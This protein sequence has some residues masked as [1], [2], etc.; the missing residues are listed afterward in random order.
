MEWRMVFRFCVMLMVPIVLVTPSCFK[1][2]F[3]TDNG[4]T[5]RFSLDTLTFD[6]VFTTVG[7]AT[8]S[9]RIINPHDLPI[10]IAKIELESGPA[11]KFRFNIDGVTYQDGVAENVEIWANDSIWVFMEVTVDPDQPVSESPFVITESLAFTT[12]GQS[13]R[14][15][16]EA[17]GQNANY[18]PNN[19]FNGQIALLSCDL[20][21]EVWSD[22]K[23]YVIYGLLL[24]D[25]CTLRIPEGTQIYVH[26]GIAKNDFGIYDDGILW[27]LQN[28]KL[29][30]EGTREKP[31]VF[32]GDR[33][34]DEFQDIEGQWGG[35][36][37]GAGSKGNVF[38]HVTVK[39]SI[40]GV[41]VDSAASLQIKGC[42]IYNT[43]SSGIIGI[44]ANIRAEN[45]LLHNNNGIG[46]LLR[47]GGDY[48]FDYVTV[49]NY[50]NGNEALYMDNFICRD[51]D[52]TIG[53][54]YRLNATMRNCIFTGSDA[55]EIALADAS[56]TTDL[57]SFEISFKNCLVRVDEL[58][59]ENQYPKF[60]EK[61]K[62]CIENK[63]FD[64]LLFKS[65]DDN[66]YH[67]DSLSIAEKKAFPLSNITRDLDGKDR[68]PVTPDIGCYEY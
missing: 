38:E 48:N 60:F 64:D 17:W 2:K 62:D 25:S 54:L 6:T 45:T 47:Y 5:V 63:S 30:A 68:D 55:D 67:L 10:K 23:P 58:L 52:C 65:I 39:N 9:F 4:A 1:E 42:Q 22:P 14:I 33:L 32:Q 56:T 15:I 13:Q 26:G 53:E 27:I 50:G 3:I 34:E 12:N 66:D 35:I 24:V 8:R 61:C 31:I 36:R 16:V 19:M 18:I 44:H 11:S 29:I 41:R 57:F 43:A 49:A 7:S 37:F 46:V 51:P 28:G 20:N 40:V 59:N 21:E